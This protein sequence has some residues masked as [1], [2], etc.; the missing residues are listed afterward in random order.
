MSNQSD[1]F[2][3]YENYPAESNRQIL[4]EQPHLD[5]SRDNP[6]ETKVECHRVGNERFGV[7]YLNEIVVNNDAIRR[8]YLAIKLHYDLQGIPNSDVLAKREAKKSFLT[9]FGLDVRHAEQYDQYWDF[10]FNTQY[11]RRNNNGTFLTGI[12]VTERD[13]SMYGDYK[14]GLCF[15]TES[16]RQ[17][18]IDARINFPEVRREFGLYHEHM[19]NLGTAD[20][21]KC[22][23]FA[24]LKILQ[25]YQNPAVMKAL[26]YPRMFVPIDR[27]RAVPTSTSY[28][29]S[30]NDLS[31]V[32]PQTRAYFLE[33][34]TAIMQAVQGETDYALM[35]RA[36]Q[37]ADKETKQ[38]E[39]HLDSLLL[40]LRTQPLETVLNASHPMIDAMR[41]EFQTYL[42]M[43]LQA[44]TERVPQMTP[45]KEKYLTRKCEKQYAHFLQKEKDPRKAAFGMLNWCLS[46]MDSIGQK[47]TDIRACFDEQSLLKDKHLYLFLCRTAE[48]IHKINGF[49]R[50]TTPNI[51]WD[52]ARV[53]Q[54]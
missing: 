49:A 53:S 36:I 9:Q 52:K 32:G 43:D 13:G 4:R 27:F 33:N 24:F 15:L 16:E 39:P 19:H 7:R 48:N 12:I 41:A 38:Y 51:S 31:Y 1:F 35:Q 3:K 6:E 47:Y 45:A 42:H 29:D 28:E 11:V 2:E 17:S 40:S 18:M 21:R 23:A 20:E 54:R 34:A 30:R 44:L 46:Q 22:D 10:L 26:L 5:F 50:Q 8:Q 14:S 25:K 37:I